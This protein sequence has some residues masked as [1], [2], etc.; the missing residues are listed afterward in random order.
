MALWDDMKD[1]ATKSIKCPGCAGN[2][3][4]DVSLKKNICHTCGNMYEPNS[5][6]LAGSAP[7]RDTGIADE[8]DTNKIEYQCDNCGAVV[9][10]DKN[11]AATFCSYCGSPTLISRRLSQE[12]HPDVI[13]PFKITKDKAIAEC[14]KWIKKNKYRPSDLYKRINLEKITGLYVPFWLIDADCHTV[15]IGEGRKYVRNRG[16]NGYIATQINRDIEFHMSKVPFDGAKH[17]DN[18]LMKALEPFDYSEMVKYSDTYL[19][20]FYAERY[21]ESFFD[22]TERAQMRIDSY[23]R[24]IVKNLSLNQFDYVDFRSTDSFSLNYSQL[25]A[26]L[27]VWF[28]RF[29]YDGEYYTFGVNGQTGEAG[30]SMPFSE[31]KQKFRVALE[32]LMFAPVVLFEIVGLF[33]FI[34]FIYTQMI[35]MM[36]VIM[37]VV[38][39]TTFVFIGNRM[40]RAAFNASNPIDSPPPVEHYINFEKRMHM[41]SHDRTLGFVKTDDD[42]SVDGMFDSLFSE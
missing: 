37:I 39:I 22:I 20:G 11:T 12:F 34:Q 21:D 26:L 31:N 1:P 16:R 19:P 8:M 35:V 29:E 13:I 36:I 7:I 14:K 24:G 38:I 32:A 23:A 42:N 30:G 28:L 17:I 15:A 18:L 9:V 5:N 3:L 41:E 4:F 2:L 10:T 6:V 40:K 33:L 27:P 25:Y